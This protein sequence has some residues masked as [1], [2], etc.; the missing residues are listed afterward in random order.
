[1]PAVIEL[2]ISHSPLA[3]I[4]SFFTPTVEINGGK[5]RLPWGN[6]RFEVSP[7]V[8]TVSVSYPWVFAPECGKNT[9]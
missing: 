1:M 2:E 8:Y 6:H 7:G 3:F 4:Y 9:V 5:Q